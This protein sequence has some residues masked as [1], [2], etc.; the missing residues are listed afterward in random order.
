[1]QK[2]IGK[3]G[4][5]RVPGATPAEPAASSIT[6]P[7]AISEPAGNT[8]PV[9]RGGLGSR[10]GRGGRGRGRGGRGKGRGSANVRSINML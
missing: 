10:G 4:K 6:E 2:N 5:K 8:L 7:S 1:M 3:Q 9:R